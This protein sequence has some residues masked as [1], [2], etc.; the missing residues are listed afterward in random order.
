MIPKIETKSVYRRRLDLIPV[1]RPVADNSAWR[2]F[3]GGAKNG[4]HGPPYVRMHTMLSHPGRPT[5]GDAVGS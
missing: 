1:G 5:H 4:G 2:M 3:D